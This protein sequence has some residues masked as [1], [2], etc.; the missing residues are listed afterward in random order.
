MDELASR[1]RLA[2]RRLAKSVGVITTRWEGQR[3]AM[4]ATAFEGLSLDPPSMLVCV[5]RTASLA[6][7]LAAGARFAINLLGSH[8]ADVSARCAAPWRGEER[9]GIGSWSTDEDAVPRLRDA[10]AVFGCSPDLVTDYGSH[11]IVIGRIE[12]VTTHGEPDP[13]L[14]VDGA[15]K[16]APV[17]AAMPQAA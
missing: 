3:L 11:Q 15:Y 10:Q 1:T 16:V 9:F 7:P 12:Q 2:L 14:Y 6:A 8:H 4:A 5:N 13:L 17:P